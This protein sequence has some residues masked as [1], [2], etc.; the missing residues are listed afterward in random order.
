MDSQLVQQSSLNWSSV[1]KFTA[2]ELNTPIF[3]NAWEKVKNQEGHIRSK[4]TLLKT[5]PFTAS[6]LDKNLL[7]LL[8][9]DSN[10]LQQELVEGPKLEYSRKALQVLEVSIF[11]F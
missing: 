2:R 10:E 9:P 6:L 8:K 11:L 3:H 5:L 7:H 4:L 1:T